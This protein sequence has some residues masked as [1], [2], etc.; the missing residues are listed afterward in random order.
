MNLYN[1]IVK[2]NFF[3]SINDYSLKQFLKSEEFKQINNWILG[4]HSELMKLEDYYLDILNLWINRK[5]LNSKEIYKYCNR[6]NLEFFKITS[7]LN[8]KI[9]Y[10]FPWIWSLIVK[11]LNNQNPAANRYN[12]ITFFIKY[13]LNTK[14]KL[15]DFI[16]EKI[17]DISIKGIPITKEKIQELLLKI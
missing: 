14:E 3:L 15:S 10:Y 1:F 7:I 13:G 5:Q 9:R 4:N 8:K 11:I 2:N 17:R 12:L 16:Y 6:N